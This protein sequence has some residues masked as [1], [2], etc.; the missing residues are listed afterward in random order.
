MPKRILYLTRKHK[1]GK[2]LDF[3]Q[4]GG[5]QEAIYV[6]YHIFCNKFTVDVVKD[7]CYRILFSGLYEKVN[8]VNCFI[9]GD[10]GIIQQVKDL[11]AT[12]GKK[13]V[14][15][16]E[17][18]GDTSYERF[19]F[20]KIFDHIKPN[21]KFL[22]IH[23]KG[24]SDSYATDEKKRENIYL[25]R[26]WMEYFLIG[27]FEI[28]LE[29]LKTHDVVGIN[30]SSRLIGP[31]FSGNFWWSTGKYYNTLGRTVG[32][33]YHDP[34]RYIFSGKPK[35]LDIDASRMKNESVGLYDESFYPNKYVD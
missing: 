22:Y 11:L 17:G 10:P 16:A 15:K 2:S 32:A 4:S 3:K 29:A 35:Y 24:I 14:V 1:K 30:Y 5:N 33:D 12:L 13:F 25:W 19:T 8:A 18:P 34:E 23:S 28:C 20:S 31:H 26:T 6:F 9:T 7:Q 21:D 27:Q